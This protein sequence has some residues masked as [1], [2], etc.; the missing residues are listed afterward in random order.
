VEEQNQSRKDKKKQQKRQLSSLKSAPAGLVAANT[1]EVGSC[2]EHAYYLEN[3]RRMQ[4]RES[5]V[6]NGSNHSFRAMARSITA[7]SYGHI[8][9]TGGSVHCGDVSA[10]KASTGMRRSGTALLLSEVLAPEFGSVYGG[11]VRS[12]GGGSLHNGGGNSAANGMSRSASGLQLFGAS[13]RQ[14]MD[15]SMHGASSGNSA[16]KMLSNATV[17]P[18]GG[19]EQPFPL[20]AVATSAPQGISKTTSVPAS[21]A[22]LAS[23]PTRRT[24]VVKKRGSFDT[25]STPASL[26]FGNSNNTNIASEQSGTSS[27]TDEEYLKIMQAR[28]T[29]N[30]S[31]L[32]NKLHGGSRISLDGS[33]SPTK[34]NTS[35]SVGRRVQ[36]VKPL[37]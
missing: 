35:G 22:A 7:A 30:D 32:E 14:Y 3:L 10:P 25:H 21:A 36:V 20:S 24:I 33:S 28:A 16:A 31:G 1:V 12:T 17:A 29:A 2:K 13:L 26:H 37:E 8:H 11:S 23:P 6:R 4:R 9:D 18:E 34:S 19:D 15:V 5:S 27:S